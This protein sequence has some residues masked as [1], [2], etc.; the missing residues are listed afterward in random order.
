MSGDE[1]DR[2][3]RARLARRVN[4]L[5]HDLQA[6]EF[7]VVHRFRHRIE[8]QFWTAEVVGRLRADGGTLGVDLC[9]GTG[10]VPALLLARLGP[11]VRL[12]CVD[13]SRDA[14]KRT[15]ASLGERAARAV[16]VKGDG[17]AVPVPDGA[18]DWV[19]LNAGLHHVPQPAT[20]LREVDRVL[21]PGGLFALGYEPNAA[22]FASRWVRGLERAIWNAF[23]YLGPKR[24]L[25][26]LRRRLSRA[27]GP[28][29]EAVEHLDAINAAL[30]AE[31]RI[32]QPL[33]MEA[34]RDLVD[35]QAKGGESGHEG[36]GLW[37]ETLLRECFP[38]YRVEA[39][40]MTD[41]GG[42]ML[43]PHAW[44]R[45]A[46]DA[47]GRLCC[48]GKGRLFSWVIRKPGGREAKA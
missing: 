3:A 23:W 38:Q 30:V 13:L 28:A 12:V 14:L 5:Y 40:W 35:V 1:A 31:G 8:R 33:T 48:G 46:Y 39:L 18:A 15:R 22:F 44:L 26:R 43:R 16:L 21:R 24:N 32:A 47:A 20:V 34:L 41:F 27:A 29:A 9:T 25:E 7:D 10:F 4:E 36:L 37:P 19:T 42:D 2:E 6:S 17:G 11:A 45:A